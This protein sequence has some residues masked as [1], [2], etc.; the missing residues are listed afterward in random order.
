M[1]GRR[2]KSNLPREILLVPP[3]SQLGGRAETPL[4]QSASKEIL[5]VLLRGTQEGGGQEVPGGREAEFC[6]NHMVYKKIISAM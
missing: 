5:L 3:W 2:H 6:A 1:T 4:E